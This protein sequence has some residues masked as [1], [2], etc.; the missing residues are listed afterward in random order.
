[1]PK[2]KDEDKVIFQ[3]KIG[4]KNEINE[5]DQLSQGEVSLGFDNEPTVETLTDPEDLDKKSYI[6]ISP[7]FYVQA[8]ELEK[9]VEKSEDEEEYYKVL[10]P[11]TGVAERRVL[12]DD[13]KHEIVVKEIKEQNI[14]FRNITHDGNITHV[15]FNASYKKNRNRK[16]RQARK[17]RQKN[18]K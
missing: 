1:M 2:K 5:L 16:N 18:R 6:K 9:D 7:T 14:K 8:I 17:S 10:N 15:K 3:P 13:E 12:T 4:N 11:E